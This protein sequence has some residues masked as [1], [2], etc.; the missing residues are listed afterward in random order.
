V[1]ESREA[2]TLRMLP[3]T[4]LEDRLPVRKNSASALE[5]GTVYRNEDG[6]YIIRRGENIHFRMSPTGYPWEVVE[7]GYK[8]LKTLM[9]DGWMVD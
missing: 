6:E 7:V 1:N 8:D 9:A 2:A 3:K 4:S 5:I